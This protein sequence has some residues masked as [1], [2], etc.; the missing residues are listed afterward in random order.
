MT[1][2][3]ASC[4]DMRLSGGVLNSIV[5]SLAPVRRSRPTDKKRIE[6]GVISLLFKPPAWRP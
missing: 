6:G 1:L 5:P 2:A 3:G 4:A